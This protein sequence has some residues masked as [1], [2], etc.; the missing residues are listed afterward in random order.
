MPVAEFLGHLGEVERQRQHERVGVAETALAARH[1]LLE[2]PPR[3]RRVVRLPV[4]SGKLVRGRQHLR[5]V[6]AAH[7]SGSQQRVL[8]PP[9]RT[10]KITSIPQGARVQMGGGQDGG[11]GH[12]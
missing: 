9:S 4:Q 6:L 3:G 10:G 8:D 11:F 12:A 5:V 2:H 7:R 1:R